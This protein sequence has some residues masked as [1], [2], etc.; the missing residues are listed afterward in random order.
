MFVHRIQGLH[1]IHVVTQAILVL[2]L[3]W[4][5]IAIVFLVA[6]YDHHIAADHYA[7][8]GV[9]LLVGFA[10]DGLRW[11][12][13][14]P[15]I[16]EADHTRNFWL[17]LQQ[18]LVIFGSMLVFLVG[19]KD[20][21]I[22]RV[23]LFSFLPLL[24]T[25]L[26]V[27]NR[28]LPHWLA[29][30]LFNGPHLQN[31]LLLGSS[32]KAQRL[33]SWLKRKAHYGIRA[34]GL[35]SDD[36]TPE[37]PENIPWLGSV[38]EI[39]TII[40][41]TGV[42]QLILVDMVASLSLIDNLTD[43]CERLGVRFMALQDFDDK[44]HQP[45]TMVEDDGLFFISLY[46]EPLE[47]PLNRLLKRAFDIT[48]ALPVVLFILPVV[49]VLVW[50]L[51]RRESPGPLFCRQDRHGLQNQIFKIWKFRTMHSGDFDPAKQATAT[52]SRIYPSGRWL[53]RHSIDEIPQFINVLLGN[54]SL[55]G[56]RPHLVQHTAEFGT[57]KRYH[58]RRFIKP[59]ITGLA[60]VESLRGEIHNPEDLIRRVEYDIQYLENWSLLGDMK[61]CLCTAWQVVAPPPTAC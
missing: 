54:M 28:I 38:S 32:R 55:V 19:S 45:I 40:K 29:S 23:F 25:A 50:Y 31:T 1:F 10:L 22:S 12:R 24:F 42:S 6:H 18:T 20:L 34:I 43:L 15:S 39:E 16:L 58:L 46:R 33:T 4:S 26:L 57:I 27:S 17:S 37:P 49:S 3:Y 8:F 48:I 44:L 7:I 21:I 59:G 13:Q 14:A 53:R 9:A 60:Q 35:V 30:V 56:P 52:D 11:V 41:S 61:I 2:S 36:Q 5:W 47:N 51:Q